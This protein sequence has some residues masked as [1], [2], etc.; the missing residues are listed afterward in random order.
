LPIAAGAVLRVDGLDVPGGLEAAV[1]DLTI[2][3][4]HVLELPGSRAFL[5]LSSAGAH[6]YLEL[7]TATDRF[8]H[9]FTERGPGADG[10]PALCR[11]VRAPELAALGYEDASFFC[12][13]EREVPGAPAALNLGAIGAPPTAP[14]T[15]ADCKLAIE[16]D[17]QFYQK[18]NSTLL[19]TNYVTQ[20]IA[21]IS[22]QYMTDVQTTLSIA[23]LGLYTNAGDPWVSQD[24]GGTASNLLDEFKNAWTSSGW[25]AVANLAHFI[26]GANLGGGVAYVNVLCNQSFGFGVSGNISGS[27]NWLTWTGAPGNFTWDFVVVAD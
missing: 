4:G 11:V 18:F 10:S 17:W 8:V 6:G 13:G 12:D 7:S 25:P 19:A 14:L 26:S 1:G 23:Y 5:A 15:A 20:L 22:D 2:W 27:I 16:T 21:A 9:L 24:G 3:T